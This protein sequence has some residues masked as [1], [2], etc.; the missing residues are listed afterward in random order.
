LTHLS[1]TL[2]SFLKFIVQKAR[3]QRGKKLYLKS[4]SLVFKIDLKGGEW[5]KETK[6]E[7]VVI[8]FKERYVSSIV[9]NY[10]YIKS[11]S[12]NALNSN[13]NH[14]VL[15]FLSIIT[16]THRIYFA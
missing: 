14:L 13:N 10:N 6:L 15:R 9:L 12:W 5:R 1:R 7:N 16:K 8:Y 2:K 11:R 4:S 3:E